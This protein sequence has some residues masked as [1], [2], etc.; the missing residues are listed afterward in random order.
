MHL[1]IH[2]QITFPFCT[3]L[4]WKCGI[5]TAW[6]GRWVESALT[7]RNETTDKKISLS[8]TWN[9]FLAKSHLVIEGLK[10]VSQTF[11]LRAERVWVALQPRRQHVLVTYPLGPHI[12]R[13]TRL[14]REARGEPYSVGKIGRIRQEWRELQYAEYL[15]PGW[16]NICFGIR[17]SMFSQTPTT[18]GCNP[19]DKYPVLFVTHN[20]NSE[21][22]QC[23]LTDLRTES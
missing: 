16:E 23:N 4:H 6:C 15:D 18:S 12:P 11:I 1:R 10:S 21:A 7:C 5:Q 14:L 3:Q 2:I 19:S 20:V 13:R 17:Q 22:T 8:Q 9:F